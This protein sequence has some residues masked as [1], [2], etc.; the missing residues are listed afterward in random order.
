MEEKNQLISV[1]IPVYNAGKHLSKCI[2]S[3]IGQSYSHFELLLVDDGSTDDSREICNIYSTKDQRI[4][5]LTKNNGGASSA[6]NFGLDHI[7]GEYVVFA[8]SD[9]FVSPDYLNNM[10]LAAISGNYDIVQCDHIDI[11]DASYKPVSLKYQSK[12]VKEITKVQALNNMV[13]KV[14]IWG[15]IYRAILFK[16]FRFPE[17]IVYEDDASYYKLVYFSKKIAV[18]HEVLYYYFLSENSVMR[19]KNGGNKGKKAYFTNIY[20][21]RI[22][23]FIEQEDE[24]LL[25]GSYVRYCIVLMLQISRVETKEEQE[26]YFTVFKDNLRNA[27]SLGSIGIKNEIMFS[28]FSIAPKMIGKIISRIRE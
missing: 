22:D 21:E 9:D 13:Y 18:I 4:H 2:D 10:Y 24:V 7:R 16:Q 26:K 5:L 8:D 15:K 11:S 3:F 17:G 20:E 27:R 19:G 23:F 28:S 1:I 12:D 6:R 14:C 25:Q